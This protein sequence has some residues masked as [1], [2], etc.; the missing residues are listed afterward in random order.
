MHLVGG[1]ERGKEYGSECTC[2]CI[3]ERKEGRNI[4]EMARNDNNTTNA[5]DQAR[6]LRIY[7]SQ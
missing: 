6:L 3:I 2:M 1:G 7:I 5:I 4:Q